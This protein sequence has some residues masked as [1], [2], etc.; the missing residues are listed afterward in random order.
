MGHGGF[1]AII[2]HPKFGAL[3]DAMGSVSTIATWGVRG[4]IGIHSWRPR[5]KVIS[6][7]FV[8]DVVRRYLGFLNSIDGVIFTPHKRL[9][10]VRSDYGLGV[11]RVD[12]IGDES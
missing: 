10:Y 4:F 8:E 11:G 3:G 7:V 6:S 12:G 5:A 9:G 2:L 1:L